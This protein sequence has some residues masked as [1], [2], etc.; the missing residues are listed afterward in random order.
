MD[1]DSLSANAFGQRAV[2]CSAAPEINY[3]LRKRL[4]APGRYEC[5]EPVLR[6]TGVEARNDM[7]DSR[8]AI[9]HLTGRCFSHR[10]R[11]NPT[12]RATFQA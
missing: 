11:V 2:A 7:Q 9:V 10:V 4:L 6:T 1:R 3:D 12:A 8:R 5:C